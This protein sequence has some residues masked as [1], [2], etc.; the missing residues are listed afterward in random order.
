MKHEITL[1]ELKEIDCDTFS[2]KANTVRGVETVSFDDLKTGDKVLI[3]NHFHTIVEV[4]QELTDIIATY[5]DDDIREQVHSEL[6]PCEPI[7]FL[8]R[9]L[10]LDSEFHEIL[11][12]EFK[13]TWYDI[14]KEVNA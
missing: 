10:E 1:K 3:D 4:T 2:R 13:I 7:E 12:E 14:C 9:Y 5:M 6:A 11:R 8:K